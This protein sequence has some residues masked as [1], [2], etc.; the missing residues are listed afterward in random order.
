[1][2]KKPS[3]FQM[4][5]A[6][7]VLPMFLEYGKEGAK[8][9]ISG[10]I[11]ADTSEDQ[12]VANLVKTANVSLYPVMDTV[13]EDWA[14]KTKTQIDDKAVDEIKELQ[15]ELAKEGGYTL[16]NLDEGTEDD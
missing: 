9:A 12:H 7:L 4:F 10:A 13:I 2:A 11:A 16:P 6:N 14:T 8:T 5:L 3:G 15:E 1:M